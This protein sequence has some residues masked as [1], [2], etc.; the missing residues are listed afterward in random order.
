MKRVLVQVG[1]N[2]RVVAIDRTS[3][4]DLTEREAL[5]WSIRIEYGD[6]IAS[7]DNITLQLKDEDWGGIF[8][9]FFQDSVPDRSIFKAVVEKQVNLGLL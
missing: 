2:N 1:S 9:D 4:D 7:Q 5:I 8:F 6:K 3:S